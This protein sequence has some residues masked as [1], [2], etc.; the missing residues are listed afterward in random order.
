[1]PVE[2]LN[3]EIL[4]LKMIV[5]VMLV[6]GILILVL[7]NVILL[8]KK[9]L[10]MLELIVFMML[11]MAVEMLFVEIYKLKVIVPMLVNGILILV[12]IHVQMSLQTTEPMFVMQEKIVFMMKM[13]MSV[14]MLFVEIL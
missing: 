6:N 11:M 9:I 13:T 5:P 1:M 10:V 3:V 2:I 12:L 4:L 8:M 14:E 7:I